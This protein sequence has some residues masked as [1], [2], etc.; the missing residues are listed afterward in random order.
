MKNILKYLSL[1]TVAVFTLLSCDYDET[2]FDSL[3][4]DLNADAT[5]YVQ[6]KNSAQSFETS[7]NDFGEIVDIDE[8]III[9]LLGTPLAQDLTVNL[10]IDPSSTLEA[11]MYTLSATSVVIPAGMTS[12]RV[13]VKSI[14]AE[15]PIG[16][17]LSLVLNLNVDGHNA[18]NGT[19]LNYNFFRI[20]FC[21]LDIN[22]FIG[23][24]VG[25]TS[26]G[27]STQVVTT[28]DGDGQL[29]ITGIGIGFM[30]NDWGEVIVDMQ[31]LPVLVSPNGDF[32][33]TEAYYM[34]TTYLG[35]PQPVYNLSAVG[36]LDS[37]TGIM[38]LDY[39][40]VQDGTSYTE[41]LTGGNGWPPFEEHITFE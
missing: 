23:N 6:F 2:N 33:I 29:W 5:Y 32:V 20:N 28:L 21:E 1:F 13:N 26:Y 18:P 10:S 25:T 41:W 31:T 22:L 15:M 39:D 34:E 16:E 17:V 24:G 9:A 12:A 8:D 14:T 11:S 3:T 40:F 27:Y 19:Q 36:K 30:E 38:H 7:V 4:T 37:C 35:V